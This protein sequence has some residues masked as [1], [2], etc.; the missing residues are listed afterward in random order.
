MGLVVELEAIVVSAP[1]EGNAFICDHWV[2]EAD[3]EYLP[4]VEAGTMTRY[5]YLLRV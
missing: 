5:L 3:R 1:A 2:R 4:A